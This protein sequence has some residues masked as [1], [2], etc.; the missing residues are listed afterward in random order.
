MSFTLIRD[1]MNGVLEIATDR[2]PDERGYFEEG[3]RLDALRELG[4]SG[5]FVQM[6]HSR[7]HRGVIRGMH[8][9][10]DEPMGKLLYCIHGSIQLI[11]LDI[12]K[13][14]PTFGEHTSILLTDEEP[15][16]VWIPPGFA[17]GFCALS[18]T[19][20]VLYHCSAYYNAK[21]EG[22]INP[23]DHSLGIMWDSETHL[24]SDKDR[25]AQ[26]FDDYECLPRF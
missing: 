15:R 3:F 2:Y 20:D 19:A 18:G 7:S 14:S 22:C 10:Y 9:Q 24:I 23:L 17:N 12:R 16:L 4:V 8:Y 13:E 11:E 21:G 1:H 25:Q 6:N 26:S 5:D